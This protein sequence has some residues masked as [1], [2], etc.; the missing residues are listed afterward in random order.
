MQKFIFNKGKNVDW[1]NTQ[2]EPFP[3]ST[4]SHSFHSDWNIIEG[5]KVVNYRIVDCPVCK[6]AQKINN[7]IMLG[8]EI[9]QIRCP[10]C[11]NITTYSTLPVPG[12]N[13]QYYVEEL[14]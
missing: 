11:N 5:E 13:I 10:W 3:L 1:T 8:H 9:V 7:K 2:N 14:D 4:A 6:K 12:M